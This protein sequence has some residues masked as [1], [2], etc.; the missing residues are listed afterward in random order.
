MPEGDTIFRAAR[1]LNRA[2]ADKTVTGFESNFPKLSRV[3]FDSGI[4]GRTILE[5]KAKGKWI[6]MQFSGDLVLLTHMLMSGSWHIYRPGEPWQRRK[7][8]MRI[9]VKTDEIWAVAFN[10]P[11]AEFHT[12]DT[13][14][15]REGFRSLGPDV[16]SADFDSSL[17]VASLRGRADLEVGVALLN[18]SLMAG[19]GN[20][21]KSEVCFACGVNPFRKIAELK[22]EEVEC[23]VR[24]AR[25]FLLANVTASSGN[26]MLTHSGLRR[27]TGRA[28]NSERL[29]VYGRRNEPCRRC[30]SV[31]ESRKQGTEARISFWCPQCQPY[32]ARI[33]GSTVPHAL[34]T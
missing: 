30:G 29:W 32:D 5:V 28:N 22:L 16:L 10:I 25:K 33:K 24:T 34:S 31:I 12:A 19:L 17:S 8:D 4:A 20:V 18:Q 13:L 1:T 21:F 15:R 23:L 2:L 6:I 26:Q 11:I 27:T 14:R 9:V 7:I 3:D